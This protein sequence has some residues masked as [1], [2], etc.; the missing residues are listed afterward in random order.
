M[1]RLLCGHHGIKQMEHL[2]LDF[3]GVLLSK[4]TSWFMGVLDLHCARWPIIS[5]CLAV[6]IP[7]NC[8]SFCWWIFQQLLHF[9]WPNSPNFG[10]DIPILLVFEPLDFP[11]WIQD[12]HSPSHFFLQFFPI[13]QKIHQLHIS[14]GPILVGPE[15]RR[16]SLAYFCAVGDGTNGKNP[17]D[18]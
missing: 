12:F 1:D 2:L 7:Q 5:Q 3:F 16:E 14:S 8:P 4:F 9:F 10:G 17:W 18:V 6:Y 15:M 13:S 11:S